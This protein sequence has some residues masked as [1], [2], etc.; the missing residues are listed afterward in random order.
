MRKKKHRSKKNPK[1]KKHTPTQV[2]HSK[3]GTCGHHE[4]QICT[5]LHGL[6]LPSNLNCISTTT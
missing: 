1:T 3:E 6:S 5:D 4:F 2:T